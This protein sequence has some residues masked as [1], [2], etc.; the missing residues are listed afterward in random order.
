MADNDGGLFHHHEGW[1]VDDGTQV[2]SLPASP[3]ECAGGGMGNSHA[4][5][6]WVILFQPYLQSRSVAFC[7][8]DGTPRPRFLARNLAEYHGGIVSTSQE[9][10][11]NSELGLARAQGL[12]M[13]SYLL[14]SIFSHR[15]ARY[16]V[17]GVLHGFATETAVSRLPNPNFIMFSERNSEAMNAPDNG[18][19]G[20]VGQDDY[21]TW[22]GEAALVRWVEGAYG[23]QGWI[24][25]NRHERGANYAY[26]DG[27]VAKLRW[28]EARRDQFPDHVVRKPLAKPVE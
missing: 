18:E 15:S 12:N 21:D 14:N 6:P 7:P 22:V 26:T 1:V 28:P 25:H 13:Q 24:R 9:P 16:A 20:N 4:E 23:D 2:E 10:P 27:H 8:S 5:K 11:L 17:E 3:A 19:F